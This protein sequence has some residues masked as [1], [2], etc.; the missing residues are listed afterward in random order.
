MTRLLAVCVNTAARPLAWALDILD[1]LDRRYA[2]ACGGD[3]E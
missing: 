3:D 2:G 1:R